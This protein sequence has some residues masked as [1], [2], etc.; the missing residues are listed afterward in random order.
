[1]E[2]SFLFCHFC[3]SFYLICQCG[4]STTV[5]FYANATEE[6]SRVE[7]LNLSSDCRGDAGGKRHMKNYVEPNRWR[8]LLSISSSISC[9]PALI[10]THLFSTPAKIPVVILK[11][12]C[13]CKGS[14]AVKILKDLIAPAIIKWT[15]LREMFVYWLR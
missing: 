5:Y 9:C 11:S 10:R 15:I 14:F 12:C 1:M 7:Y 3:L 8:N 6:F 13:L 4:R 2:L